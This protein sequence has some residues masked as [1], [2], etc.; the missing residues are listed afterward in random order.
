MSFILMVIHFNVLKLFSLT[1]GKSHRIET[2]I[3]KKKILSVLLFCMNSK[4]EIWVII[5]YVCIGMEWL[6]EFYFI[7]SSLLI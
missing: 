4:W 6:A 3:K 2:Q 1:T 5:Y 7:I